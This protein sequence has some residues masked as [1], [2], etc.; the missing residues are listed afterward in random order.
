M[1]KDGSDSQQVAV[2]VYMAVPQQCRRVWPV[3]PAGSARASRFET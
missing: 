1:S 3:Q 2:P